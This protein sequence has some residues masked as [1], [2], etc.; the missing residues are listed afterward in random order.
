MFRAVRDRLSGAE[1]VVL[2]ALCRNDLGLAVANS[3]SAVRAGA[4][5]I[6]CSIHGV[7]ERA[8]IAPLEEVALAAWVVRATGDV[9]RNSTPR[10]WPRQA[11]W[12][13]A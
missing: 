4:R 12:W 3:L 8:G 10:N 2:G 5:E 13:G 11:G 9:P 1:D 7:G 6:V